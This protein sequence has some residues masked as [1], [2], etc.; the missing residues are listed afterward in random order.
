M[1]LNTPIQKCILQELI[2][3]QIIEELNPQDNQGT[4]YHFLSN[5]DW[6]DSSLDKEACQAIEEL[7]VEFHNVF[8][9]HRFDIGIKND[10]K[11]KVT[12]I[13]ENPACSQILKMPNILKEDSIVE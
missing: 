2:A 10:L 8:A 5:F 3:L 12:P 1:R 6:T 11:A 7:L 9:W 13:D 4:R